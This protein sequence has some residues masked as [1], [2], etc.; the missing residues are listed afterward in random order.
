MQRSAQ[1]WLNCAVTAALEEPQ[2]QVQP[3][4]IGKNTVDR[5]EAPRAKSTELVIVTQKQT[6]G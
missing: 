5:L 6:Q 4:V 1:I 2:G 3:E